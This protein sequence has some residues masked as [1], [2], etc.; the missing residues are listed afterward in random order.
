MLHRLPLMVLA[1]AI[2]VAW[3]LHALTEWPASRPLAAQTEP[4]SADAGLREKDIA[5]YEM[6][7]TADTMS[8]A[9]LAQLAQL[10]LQRA[11]ETGAVED[12][13]RAEESARRSLTLRADRNGKAALARASSLLALHQFPEALEAASGLCTD[14][15]DRPSYC[16]LLGEIQLEMGDYAAAR[17]T[18]DALAP[19]R[20]NLGVAPRVARWYEITGRTADAFDL[21]RAARAE[22]VQ[23]PDL[24]REQ[25]AWFHLRVA[26][27]ALRNG[28]LKEAERAFREGLRVE[29]ADVRL[30]SGMAR[31]S[32]V[33]HDWTSAIAYG[34][35]TGERADVATLAL[36]GDAHAALRDSAA[37]ETYFQKVE[38][39]ARENPEP[40]NRQWTL[41]RLDHAREI[42]ATVALL[43]DE[44]RVR[45]D[46]YG[47]DQ[48]AW[49][50]YHAREYRAAHE[51]MQQAL[52]MGTN[53][54][55]LCFHAG[56]IERALGNHADAERHL[57]AALAAN[58]HFHPTFPARARAV[59]DSM[60][61]GR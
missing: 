33:R 61:A 17:A 54:A 50:L 57:R 32:A 53:D 14:Y 15:A 6:R 48:L 31:L 39:A 34:E 41:F 9:D 45:Q 56:L 29:P 13:G 46:V 7:A 18:F 30:L 20:A 16:A 10:Y 58:P 1:L 42:P 35:R 23:R 49:G 47:W 52:R 4:F 12:Y 43:R 19:F 5:F 36:I 27:S 28:R 3:G 25:V 40:F 26:D 22:A 21:L 59:L 37:A 8:A 60:E 51:A 44:I 11:R 38:Q 55:V 2:L 24:P